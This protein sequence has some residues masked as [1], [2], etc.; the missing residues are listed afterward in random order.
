MKET[1][2][3]LLSHPLVIYVPRFIEATFSLSLSLSLKKILDLQDCKK[4]ELF[5]S[6]LLLSPSFSFSHHHPLLV[7]NLLPNNV[8]EEGFSPVVWTPHVLDFPTISYTRNI[9][10]WLLFYFWH[11]KRVTHNKKHWVSRERETW[12]RFRK[13]NWETLFLGSQILVSV[14]FLLFVL[15]FYSHFKLVIECHPTSFFMPFYNRSRLLH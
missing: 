15:L 10:L 3:S 6:Q 8:R 1:T 12:T 13:R 11:E 14:F 9:Q 4:F 2:F 5:R 7:L